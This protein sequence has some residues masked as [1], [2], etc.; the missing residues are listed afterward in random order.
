MLLHLDGDLTGLGSIPTTWVHLP[1]WFGT[2]LLFFLTR[3]RV[4]GS[5]SLPRLR[6][7][8]AC[9]TD[10]LDPASL[11]GVDNMGDISRLPV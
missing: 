11:A 8:H 10:L 7:P 9:I 3:H 5:L 4:V 6:V 2:C 1:L